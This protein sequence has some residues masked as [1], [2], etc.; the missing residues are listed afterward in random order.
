MLLSLL[1][2]VSR[3]AFAMAEEG[4]LPRFF[5]AVHPRFKVP[6]HAELTIGAVV[7]VTAVSVDLRSAI[8][9]SSFAVLLYYAITNAAAFT[10]PPAQRRWPRA[11]AALGMIGCVLLA[12]TL[13]LE[14]VLAGAAI[15]AVGAS[16]YALKH[17]VRLGSRGS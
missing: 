7:A 8:G 9:F 10:L 4:D 15:F 6:H 12:V 17:R 14:S 11:L 16:L 1:A 2:G 13:P 3:T 5:G